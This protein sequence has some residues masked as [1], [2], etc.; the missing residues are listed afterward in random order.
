[1]RANV[2]MALLLAVILG[3]TSLLRLP[4]QAAPGAP[5]GRHSPVSSIET[6]SFWGLPYPY[7]YTWG[8]PYTYGYAHSWG[9]AG[10]AHS[11]GHTGYSW[12]RAGCVHPCGRTGYARSWGHVVYHCGYSC[13]HVVPVET[14]PGCRSRLFRSCY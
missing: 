6:V 11:C 5:L 14:H 8:P 4:A 10:C 12:G 7:G 2:G 13:R 9:Y 1:M 3:A